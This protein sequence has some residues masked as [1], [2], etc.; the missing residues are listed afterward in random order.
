MMAGARGDGDDGAAVEEAQVARPWGLGWRGVGWALG[1]AAVAG[2]WGVACSEPVGGTPGQP[3]DPPYERSVAVSALAISPDAVAVAPAGE[4]ELSVSATYEDGLSVEVPTDAVVFWME[5][6]GLAEVDAARGSIV[7]VS[8]GE[9][10]LF[11]GWRGATASAPVS[12]RFAFD[13]TVSPASARPGDLVGITLSFD[14]PILASGTDVEVEI[15]SLTPWG[16]DTEWKALDAGRY[17]AWFLLGP[18]VTPGVRPVE[19]RA[20]GVPPVG[21]APDFE[22]LGSPGFASQVSCSQLEDLEGQG[23]PD[24]E[25]QAYTVT[26]TSGLR[27]LRLSIEEGATGPVAMWWFTPDGALWS[28]ASPPASAI[29]PVELD[30]VSG[31]Q[32]TGPFGFLITTAPDGQSGSSTDWSMACALDSSIAPTVSAGFT[33]DPR[34]VSG[35]ELQAEAVVEDGARLVSQA[36]AYVDLESAF[37]EQVQAALTSPSGTE[38]LLRGEGDPNGRH[39]QLYGSSVHSAAGDLDAVAGELAS[40]SWTLTVTDPT[41]GPTTLHGYQ[42]HLATAN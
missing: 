42:I 29:L 14:P 30:V 22:V 15:P 6:E 38:V 24:P 3:Q 13:V 25:S 21:G 8:E 31:V 36:W 11:A 17:Q 37:P 23:W 5:P 4:V 9:A 39:V 40:G 16:R 1:L 19:V 33:A 41:A 7:G 28:S 20:D 35:G 34:S 18:G 27:A 32:G 10:R 26:L 2:V 12:V